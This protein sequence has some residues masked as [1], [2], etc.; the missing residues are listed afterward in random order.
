MAVVAAYSQTP[1]LPWT[2]RPGPTRGAAYGTGGRKR[3]RDAP[4]RVAKPSSTK[5]TQRLSSLRPRCSLGFLLSG[6]VLNGEDGA[7][8][9]TKS[10]TP[11]RHWMTYAEAAAYLGVTPRQLRRWTP[12]GLVP[13]VKFPGSAK[14]YFDP[15]ALDRFLEQCASTPFAPASSLSR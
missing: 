3:L 15:A 8:V 4:S 1:L 11:A 7:L 13:C 14:V 6:S 10:A 9:T 12:Q 5:A 2:Y